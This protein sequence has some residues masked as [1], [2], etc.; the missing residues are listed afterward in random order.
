L[1]DEE[2]EDGSMRSCKET[3]L[4]LSSGDETDQLSW[5]R[6]AVLLHLAMCRHCRK[7]ARQLR[8]MRVLVRLASEQV[9]LP[10]KFEDLLIARLMR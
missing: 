1:F 4:Y 3:A 9:Q 10:Q 7:F 8:R 5:R 2:G 6:F